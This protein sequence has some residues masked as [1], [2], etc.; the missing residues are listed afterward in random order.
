MGVEIFTGFGG[1][2]TLY[3]DGRVIGVQ[4]NEQGIG[5]DGNHKDTYQPGMN[6]LAKQVIFAEGCRGSLTKEIQKEFNLRKDCDP[7][8]Y[9]LG[10]KEIW[11][12]DPK[13]FKKGLVSHT[14]G[15]P[16]DYSTY[17]GSW[18]YHY[19][20]NLVS[21]GLVVGL[22][23]KNP[24]LSPYKEFQRF[25]HHKYVKEIFENGKCI[26]YG[27]R[28][29]IEGGLFALPKLHF[30]GGVLAGDT[31][32]T[33]NVA[34]IK[35]THTAMKSGILAAEAVFEAIEKDQIEATSLTERFK[36][37]WLYQ[38][39]YETRNIHGYFK[40]GLFPG[41]FLSGLDLMFLK[42][43]TPWDIHHRKPDNEKT[44]DISQVKPIVYPKPDGKISFDLLTNLARSGT[45]HDHDQPAHLKLKDNT[46]PEKVN[47]PKY[48]GPEQFYCPAS[49]YEYIEDNNGK[50][51]LQINA[52]NCL[53]CKTCDIKDPTQNIDYTIP[54]NGGGP[55]YSS[56]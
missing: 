37:S 30:P 49:V 54:V 44:L 48:G 15:W 23:Y 20:E 10:I 51:K 28:S 43:K 31:A 33:M 19:G 35:G 46:I 34:K 3:Q 27:A 50:K 18:M 38:E 55:N 17:G 25:K 22:D 11:E 24:T 21:V 29:L 45:N 32:G 40:N 6:L 5:K 26:S 56:M 7:Q 41:L 14:L 42:G 39:L 1:S 8:I 12:V 53:H 52:Q 2:K 4:T 47:L 16:L 9:G 36:S 13:V